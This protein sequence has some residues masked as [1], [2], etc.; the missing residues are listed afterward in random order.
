M[1]GSSP[2]A[3]RR[4]QEQLALEERNYLAHEV[5]GGYS[6]LSGQFRA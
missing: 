1:E 4:G 2:R 3:F 5:D 6:L